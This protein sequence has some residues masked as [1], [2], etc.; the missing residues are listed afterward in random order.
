MGARSGDVVTARS[1]RFHESIAESF[2][3]DAVVAHRMIR[4]GQR[5]VFIGPTDEQ[6][7][8]FVRLGERYLEQARYGEA[9]AAE[10]AREASQDGA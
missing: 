7:D 8:Q 9:L 6:H 1:R 2:R 10:H 5:R 4:H 3:K